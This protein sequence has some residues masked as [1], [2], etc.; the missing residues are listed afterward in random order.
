M[1]SEVYRVE[2][3][4]IVEDQSEVPIER[5]R[6]R[7]NRFQQAAE[8]SNRMIQKQMQSLAKF[9]IEPVMR[10]RDRLTASVLKA[11]KLVKRL[12]AEQ[13]APVL[14]AQDK[15][16]AVVL[17]IN[18]VLDA[19]NKGHV[20]VLADLKGPLIDEINEA[21]TALVALS[22]VQAAPVAELRGKLFGQ[23]TRAMTMARKLDQI[24][25]EPQATLRELITAK[26]R[27]INS[28]LRNLTSRAWTVTLQAKDKVTDV[29]RRVFGAIT[30]PLALLGA[31]AGATAAIAYPLSLAG[32][33]DRARRSI[34]LYSGSVKAGRKNFEELVRLA[35]KSPIYE[36]PFVVK[37]AGQLLAKGQSIDFTK[38]ALNAFGNAAMYTGASLE[39]LELAFYGFGQIASVGTLS[40]EELKQVTENLNVPL[41]WIT[42]ELGITGDQLRDLGKAGIPAQRA[43]EAIVRTLEKRFPARDFN[44][45]LLALISNVKETARVIVWKFGEGMA[46]PVVR[47]LQDMTGVLDP[48]SEKFKLF[49]EK[50]MSAGRRVGEYFERVYKRAKQFWGELSA[51]PEFQKLS[52]GDKIT[53][54][55]TVALDSIIK[56]IDGEGGKKIQTVFAKIG[57]IAA[58]AWLEG[59]KGL[60]KGAVS[61]AA[62]GNILGS[63]AMLAG[64]GMLGGGMLLRGG[65]GALKA[66]G[67]GASWL[68]KTGPA[69]KAG[70]SL[71][72]LFFG[73]DILQL[74][75]EAAPARVAEA[76]KAIEGIKAAKVAEAAKT[77][78]GIKAAKVSEAAS[79]VSKVSR[80]GKVF[81]IAGKVALPLAIAG[82]VAEFATSK[83]K[84]KTGA[85]IAGGWGGML[86]GA[87]LGTMAGGALGSII[88]GIGNVVGAAAGGL[89]GGIGGYFGGRWIG[90]KIGGKLQKPLGHPSASG[91]GADMRGYL[92]Q[93]VYEPFREY[94]NRAESWGRNLIR[95]FMNGRDSAGMSMAGWLNTK[96]YI[97]FRT[98][99]DRARLWGRNLLTNFMGGRTAAG[100]SMTGWLNTMVYIP[101][102]NIVVRATSWGRNMMI[103]FMHGRDSAGMNMA[104]WLNMKVYV[105]FASIVS[106][107]TLWGRNLMLNFVA[108][109]QQVKVPP[110]SAPRVVTQPTSVKKHAYGGIFTRPHVGLVAERGPESIVPLSSSMHNRALAIWEET[111]RRLG[112]RPYAEGGFA[113][114]VAV[115]AMAGVTGFGSTP[116][117]T[118]G[119]INVTLN[120]S[121]SG[122]QDVLQVIRANYRVIAD[123]ISDAVASGLKSVFQ[124]MTK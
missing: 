115:P 113:G 33:M 117:V 89:I 37:Q 22:K 119:P 11:D 77:I 81:R 73:E 86:A 45:D 79:L 46:Q 103:N 110:I 92:S 2:I 19:L 50:A 26:A 47:I 21:R 66:L 17:R 39:Q 20:D 96:V 60:A 36:V 104:A 109:M 123:E 91:T 10:V 53:Y 74:G 44:N 85:Q 29:A 27:Q 14:T 90:G 24:R 76:A 16:S 48:T 41:N 23:L 43:M 116:A 12:G 122:G 28:V 97:P 84:V 59:L 93:N 56:W 83:T 107:A 8:K 34:E 67:K 121:T 72:R 57:A 32:E 108:G 30:S 101:F 87:K 51:D 15:V 42:K 65:W 6:E 52:F 7:V 75:K 71:R 114:P 1:A 82:D 18:R 88:P 13:A 78:E 62:H 68:S 63:I 4:I 100:M 106:R 102:R 98:I 61:S 31:G 58:K 38:R 94:V 40:M 3:P 124:N 120:V 95:N 55:L 99:V 118:T 111:G 64:F 9:R 25:A 35:I 5:A 80:F 70:E 105:P 49:Q 54:I 112:V 69:T